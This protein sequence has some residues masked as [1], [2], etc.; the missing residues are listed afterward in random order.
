[1]IAFIRLLFWLAVKLAPVAF[2]IRHLSSAG[3]LFVA[4]LRVFSEYKSYNKQH[5]KSQKHC[6]KFRNKQ[7]Q[8]QQQ[9][10]FLRIFHVLQPCST[11]CRRSRAL[12][13]F[14]RLLLF[15][16]QK[17]YVPQRACTCHS[18]YSQFHFLL[19]NNR[20]IKSRF[21]AGVLLMFLL[22]VLL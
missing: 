4:H 2:Q 17:T 8:T 6:Y 16:V 13:F 15:S 5:Q 9:L 10:C 22:F 18:R 14:Y 11:V 21:S 12:P 7:Q 1:M 3:S 19:E 20:P